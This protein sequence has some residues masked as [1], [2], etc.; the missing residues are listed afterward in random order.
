MLEWLLLLSFPNG[1]STAAAK[2]L[3]TARDTVALHPEAEGQ[4]LVP[5]MSA[6][7]GRWNPDLPLDYTEIRATWVG[8]GRRMAAEARL[9]AAQ[10]LVIE[11]S[12][13]NMVRYKQ[14]RAMLSDMKTHV[15]VMTRD[16]YATCAS[17]HLRYGPGVVDRDWGWP[18]ARPMSESDYFQALGEIWLNRAEFLESARPDA[19]HWMRYEDFSDVPSSA[20]AGLAAEIPSL[21]SAKTGADIVVKD[22]PRQGVRNMNAEQIAKLTRSGIDAIAG[23]LRQNPG[24]VSRLGYDPAPPA[25]AGW[26]LGRGEFGL[27]AR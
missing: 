19:I 3:L 17:W 22:Y 9:D 2:I 11:K 15:A 27:I 24:L 21:A 4:W 23:A 10:P 13:P 14:L 5:A 1:G 7:R 6:P 12:P 25:A 16:P 20:V 26:P 8:A 18:G